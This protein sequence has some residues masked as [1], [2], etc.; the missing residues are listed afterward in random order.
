MKEIEVA[1][2]GFFG[3]FSSG[4]YFEDIACRVKRFYVHAVA[5]FLQLSSQSN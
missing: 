3:D 4:V 2:R 1:L 5:Q